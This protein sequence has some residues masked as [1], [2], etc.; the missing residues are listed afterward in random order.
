MAAIDAPIGT[1]IDTDYLVIG[2]GASGMAFTDAL[3]TDADVDVVMVDRRPSPGG[4]WNDAY[5][6]VRL[7]QPSATYGVNSRP[8]GTESIDAD[9]PNAGF[10]E[11]ATGVEVCDY[12]RR[13]LED[14]LVGSGQVRFL[15]QC[16]YLGEAAGEHVVVSRLSGVRTVVRV[17]RK[18]VD[19]TYLESS[20]PATHTPAFA[21][22]EGVTMIPVGRL[23]D[24]AEPPGGFTIL[25]AGK[26]AM[27][28]CC[29]LLDHGVDPGRIA[30][31]RPRDA[32][33]L[34]RSAF[35]PLELIAQAM[36]SFALALEVM[37]QA[38]DLQDLL[39]RLEDAGDL[40]RLD[41]TVEPAMFRGAIVSGPEHRSLQQVERVVR[42]GRVRRIDADRIVLEGGELAASSST[43]YVDCTAYGLKATPPRPIFEPGRITPQSLMGAFTTFN[44]ALLGYV[45]A[46]R[47][48]DDEKNRL[49]PPTPYPSAPADWVSIYAGGFSTIT[50]LMQEPDLAEWLGTCRLNATRGLNDHLDDPRVQ[51]A[52][53]RWFEHLEPALANAPRLRATAAN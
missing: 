3:I 31:V 33:L 8:L 12:F 37:A 4:H 36:E 32:W 51:I 1:A 14:Q 48:D 42:Q 35:Q 40:R 9:G 52:L 30:W 49:C 5:P 46:A 53:G 17:R 20:V 10:Y 15:G 6:F 21:I 29:F 23:V 24:V 43:L 38:E 41:A 16:D 25:G 18:L 19:A 22:G 34:D 45:E 47:E 7:H 50:Q 27:D 11:R 39:R 13:V 28:A 26:T 2:A 44:A